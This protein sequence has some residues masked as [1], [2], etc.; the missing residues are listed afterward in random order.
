MAT[1]KQLVEKTKVLGCAFSDNGEKIEVFAPLGKV[2][3]AT[4]THYMVLYRSSF[5]GTTFEMYD[6]LLEDMN[7]GLADCPYGIDCDWCSEGNG[8][9]DD[10]SPNSIVV[11]FPEN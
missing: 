11:N 6:Y 5:G 8:L 9:P 3:F 7:P 1:R 4:D 2:F 10:V